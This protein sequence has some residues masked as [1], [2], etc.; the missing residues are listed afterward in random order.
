MGEDHKRSPCLDQKKEKADRKRA[1][2][3]ERTMKHCIKAKGRKRFKK[4][5]N[6]SEKKKEG[7]KMR[8]TRSTQTK[9]LEI[10]VSPWFK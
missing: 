6:T 5:L 1:I 9:Y 3:A 4:A 7:K 8:N 10:R 2:R